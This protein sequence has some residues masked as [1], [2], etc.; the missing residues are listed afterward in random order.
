MQMPSNEIVPYWALPPW[1]RLLLFQRI[2]ELHD[3]ECRCSE[4]NVRW[5]RAAA[6]KIGSLISE[7]KECI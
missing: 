2:C 4:A 3:A 7:A 1:R 5:S 6:N